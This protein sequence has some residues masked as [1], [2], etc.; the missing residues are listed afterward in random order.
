MRGKTSIRATH[1]GTVSAGTHTPSR[2]RKR[3]IN[4]HTKALL[5]IACVRTGRGEGGAME[6]ALL[7]PILLG[8]FDRNPTHCSPIPTL[9]SG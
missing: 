1:I 7:S 2:S 5:H 3:L 6:L 9:M 4:I 8:F